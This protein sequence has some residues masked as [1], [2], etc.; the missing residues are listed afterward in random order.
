MAVGGGVLEGREQG[1]TTGR[2]QGFVICLKGM[3]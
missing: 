3:L 1:V 2:R